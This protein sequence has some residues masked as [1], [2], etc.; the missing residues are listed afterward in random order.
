MY[1]CSWACAFSFFS[2]WLREVARTMRS[3]LLPLGAGDEEHSA[4]LCAS[5]ILWGYVPTR[6]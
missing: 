3:H 5:L 2:M 6:E 4:G 1:S